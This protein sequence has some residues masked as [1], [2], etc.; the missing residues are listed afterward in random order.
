MNDSTLTGL[1][2]IVERAVRP[3]EAS[4]ARKRKMREELLAHVSGVFE[5]ESAKLGDDH[6][7]L[8]Q[9]ALRF[10]NPTEVT[11]QLQASVPAGDN[12]RRIWEGRPAEPALR[13][14]LRIALVTEVLAVVIYVVGLLAGGW[15]SAWP[16]EAL[17]LGLEAVLALP[18][19]LFGLT[20]LTDWME[21]GLQRHSRFKVTLVGVSSWLFMMLGLA[22]LTWRT[23]FADL[24]ALLWIAWL[25][26]MALMSPYALARSAVDRRRYHE[27]WA[28][29][30]LA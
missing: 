2:T 6:A 8:E 17:L 10:G 21:K 16:R 26:P 7:A 25:T 1:K 5:E 4:M 9:T 19:Y 11:I 12:I 27:E 29:L 15:A 18:I 13:A 22:G 20:F 28:R 23:S 3:V 24:D 14:A 30:D